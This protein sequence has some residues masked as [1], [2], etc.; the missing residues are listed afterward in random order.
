[1]WRRSEETDVGRVAAVDVRVRNAAEHR[2]VFP[3]LLEQLQIRRQLISTPGLLG[4]EPL[5]QQ[6]EVVADGQH[7]ARLGGRRRSARKRRE[8]RF[9]QRQGKDN[10]GPAQ[11]LRSEEHTSEL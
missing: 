6:S 3:V 11:K 5:W 7:P 10:A 4:K 2:E 8:H 9:Q 1:M